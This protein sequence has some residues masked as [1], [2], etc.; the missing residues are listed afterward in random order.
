M[1]R[2]FFPVAAPLTRKGPS[3]QTLAE[4][5]VDRCSVWIIV[6]ALFAAGIKMVI[7][8]CTI[9]TNDVV[10]FYFFGKSLID[11]GLEETYKSM[12]SFNH[13]PL[14]AYYLRAIF[15]LQRLP[16][17]Q[18]NQISFPFLLRLP[19]IVAD[20]VVVFL[21]VRIR[22]QESQFQVPA[23][24]L[25]LFALSPLSIMVSGFHGNTDPV[26]VM[27]LA[28]S[29][30][31][32][33]RN[34]PAF[35]GLFLALSSQ[36]KIIP[37]LFLPIILC[38]WIQRRALF[39]FAIPFAA[40]SATL[41]SEPLL[42]FPLL[43]AKNVFSYSSYW[44]IWGISYLLRLTGRPEFNR[45]SF[46]DLGS[47]QNLVVTTCKFVIIAAVLLL[48]WRR[49]QMDGRGLW[50]SVTYAWVIFFVFSPGVCTQYLIWLAP[51]VLFLSPTF[52]CYLLASSSAFAFVF[53]DTISQG[54]PW[55]VGISTNY[56]NKLWTPW[57]L[58][59]WLVLAG[60]LIVMWKQAKREDPSLRLVSLRSVSSR[61]PQ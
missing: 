21:L 49:R 44:G 20:L 41:W 39:R 24:V 25:V 35:C 31:Y 40:A 30:Y 61:P 23:W 38:F 6:C 43:F 12:I 15:Y 46:F 14:T 28:F 53:Y 45:V 54:L 32:C 50:A 57:S 52:Y 16:W 58:L 8:Y 33:L 3:G 4:P 47:V 55:Y 2:F 11:H 27:L 36:V 9:G 18:E 7:A 22:K 37:L 13:P 17:F 51:F 56:L 10:S 59:P 1:Q 26:M 42:K 60:G 29:V 5:K 34:Q 19:G 48:A